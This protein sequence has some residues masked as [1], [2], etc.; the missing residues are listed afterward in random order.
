[1]TAPSLLGLL[2]SQPKWQYPATASGL[3]IVNTGKK[4]SIKYSKYTH[5]FMVRFL[6]KWMAWQQNFFQGKLLPSIAYCFV[7]FLLQIAHWTDTRIASI[8]NLIWFT[9]SQCIFFRYWQ[10]ILN[11]RSFTEYYTQLC[12]ICEFL[13]SK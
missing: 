10:V 3:F 5:N 2:T 1:M 12:H 6:L 11:W 13:T 4:Q 8:Y 9:I 7:S